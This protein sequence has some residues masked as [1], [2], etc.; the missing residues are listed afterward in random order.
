M[1]YYGQNRKKR[2]CSEVYPGT[3]SVDSRLPDVDG[4]IVFSATPEWVCSQVCIV[5][6]I[7]LFAGMQILALKNLKVL[8]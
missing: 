5:A 7:I 4:R 2:L 3:C 8:G 6:Q 1:R